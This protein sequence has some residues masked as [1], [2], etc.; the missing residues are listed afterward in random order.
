MDKCFELRIPKTT[1]LEPLDGQRA[2]PEVFLSVHGR[3]T[4]F[5][6]E[7]LE[8][9]KVVFTTQRRCEDANVLQRTWRLALVH[10]FPDWC[11]LRQMFPEA[12]P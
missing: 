6:E 8:G 1:W 7:S 4:F 2:V 9:F 5:D 12:G 10:M 3:A 11:S